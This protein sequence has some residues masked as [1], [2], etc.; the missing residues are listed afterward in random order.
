MRLLAYQYNGMIHPWAGNRKGLHK[1]AAMCTTA[2]DSDPLAE[3]ANSAF[4][5]L[6]AVPDV[7]KMRAAQVARRHSLRSPAVP[8]L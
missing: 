2:G 1:W 6:T 4:T 3:L 7:A 8:R 5:A